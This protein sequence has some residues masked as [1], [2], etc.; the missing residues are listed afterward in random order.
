[1]TPEGK[2]KAAIKGYLRTLPNCW[3]FMPATHGYGV[4]GVPDIVGCY[5]G[6]FFAIECKAPGKLRQLTALQAMQIREINHA[7]GWAIAADTLQHVEELF[8]LI[9]ISLGNQRAQA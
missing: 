1:M 3:F 9:D 4:N 7:H 5:K 6:V 2:V 8:R